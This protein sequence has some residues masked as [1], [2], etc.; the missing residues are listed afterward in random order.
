M[1]PHVRDILGP[2]REDGFYLI[3]VAALLRR[4]EVQCDFAINRVGFRLHSLPISTLPEFLK[5]DLDPTPARGARPSVEALKTLLQR[6]YPGFP[7]P[8]DLR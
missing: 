4:G 1:V 7:L 5:S 6:E 2:Y 8:P 3:P